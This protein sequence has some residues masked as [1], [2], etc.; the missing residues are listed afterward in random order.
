VKYWVTL[1]EQNVFILLGYK[2]ALHPPM[3]KDD[4]RMLNANHIASLANAKAIESFRK[5]VPNGMIGPSF[6]FT[7]NYAYTCKTEDVLAR[8]NAEDMNC[9]WWLDIYCWGTY[10]TFT[11]NMYE[12]Q[13]VAPEIEDGDI[14][15][16]E[17]GKPDFIGINYYRSETVEANEID[18]INNFEKI[19]TSGKKGTSKNYGV[20]GVFKTIKNPHLDSTNWDWEI[21]P[22]GL[23]IGIRRI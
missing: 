17:R 14:E 12:K 2:L 18:G 22:I 9:H 21:D 3:I 10:P 5:Y 19:N 8:E 20:P 13:G 15:L 6:A 11:L 23:R 16:L 4:K 7:P 1:N